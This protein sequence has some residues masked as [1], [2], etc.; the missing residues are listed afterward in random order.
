METFLCFS[1]EINDNVGL[2]ERTSFKTDRSCKGEEYW[3]KFFTI[4]ALRVDFLSDSCAFCITY[5]IPLISNSL[6]LPMNAPSLLV[7]PQRSIGQLHLGAL[8]EQS[9]MEALIH[10]LDAQVEDEFIDSYTDGEYF[11]VCTWEIVTCDEDGHVTDINSGPG[12]TGTLDFACLPPHTRT[13]NFSNNMLDILEGTVDTRSLPHSLEQLF[14]DHN[15]FSGDLDLRDLPRRFRVLDASA[16]DFSGSCHLKGL[17]PHFVEL[18]AKSNRFAGEIALDALP[19]RMEILDL[20]RN[21]GLTGSLTLTHLPS[22]MKW[23]LLNDCS[24]SGGVTL[25]AFPR[26]LKR[27]Q[28]QENLLN[29][30]VSI[31]NLPRYMRELDLSANNFSGTARMDR[32]DEFRVSLKNNSL[33]AIADEN[34]AVYKWERKAIGQTDQGMMETLVSGLTPKAKAQFLECNHRGYKKV[35]RWPGVYTDRFGRVTDVRFTS[36][37]GVIPLSGTVDLSSMPPN[38]TFCEISAGKVQGTVHTGSLPVPLAKL[39]LSNNAISGSF[40][41]ESLPPE[42]QIIDIGRNRF[43]G[44]AILDDLPQKLKELSAWYNGFRGSL[45]LTSLPPALWLLRLSDCAFTG[46]VDFDHFPPKLAKV[47]LSGNKLSGT[48][49]AVHISERLMGLSVDDNNFSGTAVLSKV[50]Y[51][52]VSRSGNSIVAVVDENGRPYDQDDLSWADE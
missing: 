30:E 3:A 52:A 4:T 33:D 46:G 42:L 17:P 6:R 20:S 23:L 2:S 8:S 22:A 7:L 39:Y 26:H 18:R 49:R 10:G 21:G 48:L 25:N 38:V 19:R 31:T 34:G 41:F 45:N 1:R 12:L 15:G 13:C 27:V 14:V 35:R 40:Q 44:S 36:E 37:G 16:N 28:L 32:D 9:L 29:G 5:P 51:R 43:T 50:A 11:P 24:F 47:F